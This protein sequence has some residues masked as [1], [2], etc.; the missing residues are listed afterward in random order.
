[1]AKAKRF[2][3]PLKPV[4]LP[5]ESDYKTSGVG[6]RSSFELAIMSPGVPFDPQADVDVE[7]VLLIAAGERF[8]PDQIG[9]QPGADEKSVR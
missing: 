6:R 4:Y 8:S 7:D 1:V 3:I 2:V 5:N 9:N